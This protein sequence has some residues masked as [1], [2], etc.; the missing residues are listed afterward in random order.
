VPH[1]VS[2][3]NRPSNTIFAQTIDAGDA[4]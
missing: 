2:E 1:R 3:G 4:G